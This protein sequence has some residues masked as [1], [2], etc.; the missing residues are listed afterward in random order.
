MAPEEP[1]QW[2]FSRA[3]IDMVPECATCL[4]GA[5]RAK[6]R[7][8]N[9]PL[10]TSEPVRAS[11]QVRVQDWSASSAL[12]ISISQPNTHSLTHTYR[13]VLEYIQQLCKEWSRHIISGFKENDTIADRTKSSSILEEKSNI[14][15]EA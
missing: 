13:V 1:K 5:Q 12:C 2:K 15:R 7:N 10:T 14:G 8:S 4:Y 11:C 6:V 9:R 3:E